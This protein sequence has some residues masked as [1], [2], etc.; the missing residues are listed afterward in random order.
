MTLHLREKDD[1]SGL[2]IRIEVASAHDHVHPMSP[3]SRHSYQQ[4][5]KGKS[6]RHG[7]C[8]ELIQNTEV[9]GDVSEYETFGDIIENIERF[10]EHV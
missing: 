4:H 1:L 2:I 8:G 5:Q 7:I 10:I 3:Q 9:R 6:I